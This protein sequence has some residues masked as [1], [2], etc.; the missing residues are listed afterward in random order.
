MLRLQ[1][2]MVQELKIVNE[3]QTNEPSKNSTENDWL[4]P[5]DDF[6]KDDE[7]VMNED[8]QPDKVFLPLPKFIRNIIPKKESFDEIFKEMSEN[9]PDSTSTVQEKQ[10]ALGYIERILKSDAT[11]E[12]K[13]YWQNKKLIIQNEIKAI[14][15]S[16]SG[17]PESFDAVWKEFIENVPDVTSTSIEKE[18]A[19]SY[20][21]RIL[22]SDASDNVKSYWNNKASQLVEEINNMQQ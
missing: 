17:K 14:N 21:S 11:Q 16:Q 19:L 18:L 12:Q 2:L 1:K 4:F 20:I 8:K 10:A 6:Q 22:N 9:I 5:E 7:G 3:S 13:D 15:S